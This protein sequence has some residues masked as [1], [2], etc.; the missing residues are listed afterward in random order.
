MNERRHQTDDVKILEPGPTSQHTRI[1]DPQT[2]LALLTDAFWIGMATN[3]GELERNFTFNLLPPKKNSFLG[4][5][6]TLTLLMKWY[7]ECFF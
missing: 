5:R 1:P 3:D 6:G 2:P 4:D 7:R